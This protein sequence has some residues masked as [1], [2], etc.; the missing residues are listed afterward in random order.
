MNA[1]I[2]DD[3]TSPPHPVNLGFQILLGMANAGAVVSLLPIA[4]VLIPA[5][6]T[7]LDPARAASNLAMVL[8]LGAAGALVGNALAGALS[9]R[10]TSRFGRRRPWLLAGMTGAALGLA[11]LANSYQVWLI[12]AGWVMVQFFGN[13]LLSSYGAILP[14]RVPNAQRGT[15]QAIIGLSSPIAIVLS[16]ILFTQARDLRAAYYPIIAALVCLTILFLVLYKEPRLP[17]EHLAPFRLRTFLSSFWLNPR[18]FPI[19]AVM[20]VIWLLLWSGFNLGNGGFFFLFVQDITRYENLFPGH[21]VKEGIATL[22][23]LQIVV[24]VPLMIAAGVLS[25]RIGRRKPFVIAGSLLIAAGLALLIISSDWPVVAAASVTIGAGFWIFYNLGLA[26]ITQ[27][28]PSASN[29][30]KDLGVIN[31]AATLPQIVIPPLGA[32][33]IISLGAANPASYQV[34]FL[35]GAVMVM[36]AVGLMRY[37][38]RT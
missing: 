28:L 22:Q 11:L 21:Q 13:M 6:V 14:D 16:N 38:G 27:L 7:S 29:R 24:G 1:S 17:K 19:F 5:Q 18:A 36:L 37:I 30:G 20:W 3:I 25:D 4:A 31:I 23:I 9:D 2:P 10:T 33:V 35:S 34:L 32:A 15:T 26:M 8:P 12:A